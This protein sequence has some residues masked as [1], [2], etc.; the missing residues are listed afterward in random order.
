MPQENPLK[1]Y[2]VM[3]GL[4][5]KKLSIQAKVALSSIREKEKNTANLTH[6]SI[7]KLL[8]ILNAASEENLREKSIKLSIKE[9][10]DFQQKNKLLTFPPNYLKK[11]KNIFV[12]NNDKSTKIEHFLKLKLVRNNVCSLDY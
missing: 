7:L 8:K 11:N 1:Y 2:R 10:F 3:Q 5:Q 9:Y 12:A 4:T 6:N